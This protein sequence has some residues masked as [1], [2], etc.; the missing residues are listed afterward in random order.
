MI[1][2]IYTTLTFKELGLN[3]D[4]L[5]ALDHMNF[6]DATPIQEQAIPLVL[7]GKDLIACA[8]TGTGKT[9]AFLLPTLD[10]ISQDK[11]P[12]VKALIVCPTRE[13]AIQIDR[14]VQGLAY[15]LGVFSIP[16]YGGGGGGNWDQQKKALTEGADIIVAT[17]GK[18]ISHLN[19]GYVNFKNITHFILDEAD[20]MMDMGFREDIEK[21]ASFLPKK[22]QNLMFSATMPDK[23][24][25]LIKTIMNEKPAQVNLA[26]S[27]PAAGVLQAAYLVNDEHKARLVAKLIADKPNISKIIIFTSTKGKVKEIQRALA[28]KGYQVGAISSDFEQAERE[29]VLR[30]FKAERIRVLVGTDVISRGIDIK[31][32]NLVINYDVPRQ[33]EDYVHRVGRTARAATTGVA[34]TLINK[35]DMRTFSKI[36][37]LIET[38]VRKLT[39]PEEIG[40]SPEWNPSKSYGNHSGKK[41]Y[42]KKKNK[43]YKKPFKKRPKKD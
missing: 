15:F 32:I 30:K 3:N 38:E 35:D 36:E 9:A 4:L 11:R 22:R 23:I 2:T 13:L 33:A 20:R 41:G 12:G 1:P 10:K 26:I 21:I 39:I 8:Q 5:E 24:R 7:E 19:M 31:D 34:I 40:Q 28:N 43:S 6:T 29:E 27:K 14:Q 37:Q 16:I 25:K 42:F 18:L 17:P